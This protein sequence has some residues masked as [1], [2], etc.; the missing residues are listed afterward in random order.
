MFL[1]RSDAGKQLAKKLAK[2]KSQKGVVLAVPRGGVVV[3]S[4]VAS[5]LDWPMD[6]LLIKKLGHPK[7]KE[8]AIGAVS[9]FDKVVIPHEGVSTDYIENETRLI[10]ERLIEMRQ[11][12]LGDAPLINLENQIVIVVDDGIATGNT[13][14]AGIE[15]L[16]MQRP[17]KIVLAVPV[18]PERVYELLKKQVDEI[19]VLEVA[20]IFYGVGQ[21]YQDFT[22]VSDEEV[23]NDLKKVNRYV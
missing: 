1:N 16:K 21:F 5:E 14:Y 17:Q 18:G 8:Y 22:E 9:L 19:I 15:L 10:R 6:L 2:Y 20:E 3:A 12:F 4:E 13:I 11:K 23:I 7:N